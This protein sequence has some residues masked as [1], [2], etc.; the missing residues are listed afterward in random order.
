MRRVLEWLAGSFGALLVF[1]AS[2]PASTAVSNLESYVNYF[3]L[4]GW[5]QLILSQLFEILAG[6]SGILGMLFIL[7]LAVRSNIKAGP[8]KK[9]L[10]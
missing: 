5:K 8:R 7:W 9:P 6:L 1:A 2:V 10:P 3:G 4:T